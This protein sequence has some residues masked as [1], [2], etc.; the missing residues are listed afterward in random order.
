MYKTGDQAYYL[1]DGQIAFI[2]RIDDQI[3]IRG[4]RIE[5]GEIVA[6]LN[7][8]PAVQMSVVVAREDIPGDKRLV[9][10]IVP[11]TGPP[12]MARTFHS[13]LASQLPDYMVPATFVYLPQLPLTT[14]GKV[15]RNA[16]PPPDAINTLQDTAFIPPRT[17]LEERLAGILAE[18][19]GLEQ[20]GVE[21]NFFL[22]GG[23]SLLGTQVIIRVH[24][25]FGVDLPQRSLFEAPTVALLATEIERL[26][27]A[28]LG[29]MSEYEAQRVL[30]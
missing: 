29:A 20:V 12:T 21:D 4:Y 30:D 26:I 2:G 7:Q 19:L 3:K 8:H 23:H 1:R 6:A 17:P 9:A 22:L 27:L 5:P 16:L 10:Y 25:A 15:D 14:N 13:F 28:R 24:E 11:G 18:L